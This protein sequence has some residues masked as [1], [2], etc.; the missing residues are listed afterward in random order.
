MGFSK[1]AL[2]LKIKSYFQDGF[3]LLA[4]KIEVADEV[5]ST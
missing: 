5:S 4:R 3:D 2:A 1:R